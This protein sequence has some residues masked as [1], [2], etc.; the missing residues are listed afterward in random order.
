MFHEEEVCVSL[1]RE[2]RAESLPTDFGRNDTQVTGFESQQAQHYPMRTPKHERR[3]ELVPVLLR[4]GEDSSLSKT[5]QIS[6]SWQL[7][8]RRAVRMAEDSDRSRRRRWM[9][10]NCGLLIDRE[11]IGNYN[12]FLWLKYELDSV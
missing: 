8:R 11:D 2:I 7:I 5:E 12:S 1:W 4:R 9:K 10:V 6:V 3:N